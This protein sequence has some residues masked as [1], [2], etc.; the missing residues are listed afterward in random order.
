MTFE[1][2]ML[3]GKPKGIMSMAIQC[4]ASKEERRSTIPEM[5]V[6]WRISYHSKRS[7]S[8]AED[9]IVSALWKHKGNTNL[10][11]RTMS[12]IQ[13]CLEL[14]T[15]AG[16]MEWQGSLRATYDKYLHPDTIDFQNPRL[17]E[18]L[19]SQTVPALFQFDSPQGK[20]GLNAVKPT[21]LVEVS[22]TNTLIRLMVEEGEQP[23]ARYV[24]YR[25]NIEEWYEDMRAYGLNEQEIEI[26]KRYLLP[27]YGVMNT[28][29]MLMIVSQSEDVSCF[30]VPTSNKLRKAIAKKNGALYDE[31]QALFYEKGLANGCRKVFL[32]YIWNEQISLSKGYGFSILHS[33]SYSNILGQQLQLVSQ[34]PSIYWACAV[35][36]VES[37]SLE[38]ESLE[39]EDGSTKE[40]TTNYGALAQAIS[41]LQQSGITIEP[42]HINS[43][44]IGFTPNEQRNSITYGLKGVTKINNEI[45]EHIIAHRPY[46]SFNDFVER[47][48]QSK[49]ISN[50]QLISLIKAGAFDTLEQNVSRET[51]METYLRSQFKPRTMINDKLIQEMI[52]LGLMTSEFETEMK[53]YYFKSYIKSLPSQPDTQTKSIKWHTVATNNAYEDDYTTQYFMTHFEA[54]MTEERDYRYDEQGH[55]QI[56]LGTKRKGSFEDVVSRFLA[57]WMAWLKSDEGLARYNGYQYQLFKH[58]HAKGTKEAWEMEALSIYLNQH[59]VEVINKQDHGLT[60]FD[61]LPEDAEIIG[62]NSYKGRQI[63]KFKLSRLAGCV[64][65]KDKNKHIVYLLTEKGCVTLKLHAGSFAHYDK[66]ISSVDSQTGD[67]TKL[68]DSWFK[69]GTLLM[70]TGYRQG[71]N[72]KPK[73]YSDSI[74]K[75]S[76]QRL[77]LDEQQQLYIQ[78]ERY[79]G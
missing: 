76:I 33:T 43:A 20:L 74:V 42:P 18:I 35:L 64:V 65:D 16:H 27:D 25:N 61:A 51:L 52:E 24:R 57:P 41:M 32:E 63:P 73:T 70:V 68:E 11:T 67:K 15:Q 10:N 9:D 7:P 45:A 31:V 4:E 62:Y 40:K 21:S 54:E 50:G 47:L 30:D 6:G 48:V 12:M 14:L 49:H 75:H 34:Y 37:G 36:Q 58:K 71:D 79:Q 66:V 28:Q 29:E 55:L 72:F 69:K 3:T 2:D 1:I 23:L 13:V 19:N 22:A 59:E 5:E 38:Q 60:T 77:A 39:E 53:H 8:Q 46:A 56:A 26:M 17:W 78:A 44:Q